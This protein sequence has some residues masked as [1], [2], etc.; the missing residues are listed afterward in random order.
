[1]KLRDPDKSNKRAEL[2]AR[3]TKGASCRVMGVF[4]GRSFSGGS[5]RHA[6]DKPDDGQLIYHG[7]SAL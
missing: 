5:Q 1:M 7:N 4:L 3:G 6:G 2:Y